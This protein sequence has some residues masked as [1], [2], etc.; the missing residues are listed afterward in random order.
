MALVVRATGIPWYRRED[1]RRIREIMTDRDKLHTA[2]RDW[3]KAAE[4]LEAHLKGQ[5]HVVVRAVID[6]EQFVIWCAARGLNIDAQARSRFAN[7][8]AHAQVRNTH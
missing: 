8:M 3:E 5:G 7:E 4:S 2:H 6:P 1:Y